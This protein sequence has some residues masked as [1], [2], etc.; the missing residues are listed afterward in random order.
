MLWNPLNDAA[1]YR[2]QAKNLRERT[3]GSGVVLLTRTQAQAIMDNSRAAMSD[4][5]RAV[6]E[7]RYCFKK[8]TEGEREHLRWN[9][10]E[11]YWTGDVPF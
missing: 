4:W 5:Q 2:Q 6:F 1:D 3:G 8:E 9:L 7:A 10:S 11:E